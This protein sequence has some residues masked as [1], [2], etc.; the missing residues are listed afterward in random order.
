MPDPHFIGLAGIEASKDGT[1]L[2]VALKERNQQFMTFTVATEI[3]E[4]LVGVLRLEGGRAAQAHG[5]Q[6]NIQFIATA[7]SAGIATHPDGQKHPT[8]AVQIQGGGNLYLVLPQ[9]L[10]DALH[11]EMSPLLSHSPSDSKN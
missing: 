2:K 1:F 9:L 6:S 11:A 4:D 10:F 7:A 3:L 8:I 5:K